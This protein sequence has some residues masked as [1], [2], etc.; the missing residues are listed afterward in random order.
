MPGPLGWTVEELAAARSQDVV[1]RDL[2]IKNAEQAPDAVSVTF[3]DGTSWTRG[4]ALAVACAAANVLRSSGVGA[5]DRVAV[6]LP[7][8]PDLLATQWGAAMLGAVTVPLNTAFLGTMLERALRL[9]DPAVLVTGGEL[10]ARIDDVG[11]AGIPRLSPEELRG[12]DSSVPELDAEVG[13]WDDELLVMTSGTTGPSKLVRVPYFYPYAGYASI[14]A[15]QGFGPDEV[16]LVDLPMFHMAAAGYVH[17]ALVTGSRLHVRS[18]PALD[19]YW[20]V[21][22]DNDISSAVLISS[23]VPMLLAQPVVAAEREH[24]LR[25][26]LAA[27]VPADVTAFQERFDVPKILTSWGGTEMGAPVIGL[28][29]AG[30]DPGYCGRPRPGFEVRLVDEHDQE[31]P[32]GAVGEGIVRA[33]RPFMM[34]SGY[35]QNPEATATAWRH[36]WF[37]T[38]DL[39]REDEDGNLCFVDRSGDAIRRRGENISAYEV[40]VGMS[41]YPGIAEV[42]VVSVPSESGVEHDVKAWVV[43]KPGVE[44]DPADLLAHCAAQLPH[45]MVPRYFE[46]TTELPKTP[47][48][49]VQKYVL[50]ERGNTESTWDSEAHGLVVTRRGLERRT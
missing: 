32:R 36:G 4:E 2:L 7:N 15:S 12:S 11:G 45:F 22:R 41:T 31:V 34:S 29:E 44:L 33:M 25:F 43:P 48:A 5:G 28:G 26:L 6:F 30:R 39:L 38:G 50:R 10:G 17:A 1:V 42:A 40:E 37:H 3:E 35:F 20:E 14:L 18:R 19:G 47:S 13:L 49:K 21:V 27:P 46:I 16:Y 9:G 8:G 23:M 24:R